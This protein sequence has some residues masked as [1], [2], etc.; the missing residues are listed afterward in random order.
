MLV[1]QSLFVTSNF[2]TFMKNVKYDTFIVCF[3]FG[4]L[5]KIIVGEIIFFEKQ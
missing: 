4:F 2:I 1:L 3:N 5:S